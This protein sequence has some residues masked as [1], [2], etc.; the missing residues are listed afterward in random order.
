MFEKDL[1]CKNLQEITEHLYVKCLQCLTNVRLA[2]MLKLSAD[3][4]APVTFTSFTA[5]MCAQ[6]TEKWYLLKPA[7]NAHVVTRPSTANFVVTW[8]LK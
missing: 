6:G 7:A 1:I 4:T 8:V 2:Y 5:C 3:H